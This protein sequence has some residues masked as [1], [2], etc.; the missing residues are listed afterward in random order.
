MERKE[1][2]ATAI[3]MGIKNAHT[4]K[5][6][7]LEEM[8]K[9]EVVEK[10]G[11]RGRPVNPNSTRQVRIAELAEKRANG[12]LR[13]GRPVNESSN[14][15]MRLVEL[16]TKRANGELRKGRPVSNESARQKRIAELEAK[17]AANGGVMP[18]G[19][20]KVVIDETAS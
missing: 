18:L 9:I 7:V 19:R 6:V 2:V 20:P 4:I 13:R 1:L 12:E 10:T 15:Q 5:S 14:R 3:A 16:E 11:K 17:K 8:I